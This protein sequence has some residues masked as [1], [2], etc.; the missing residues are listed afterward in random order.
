[1]LASDK[2]VFVLLIGTL[3]TIV[4]LEFIR[5]AFIYIISGW[6]YWPS[7]LLKIWRFYVRRV[8]SF[9]KKN[10]VKIV[11]L[12]E[13]WE[14]LETQE[15]KRERKSAR[16]SKYFISILWSLYWFL[17]VVNDF[18]GNDFSGIIWGIIGA[19]LLALWLF[20]LIKW[21]K[22]NDHVKNMKRIR[23]ATI[24]TWFIYVLLIW[25]ILPKTSTDDSK[26]YNDKEQFISSINLES[27]YIDLSNYNPSTLTWKT[28]KEC[29]H[30]EIT[31]ISYKASKWYELMDEINVMIDQTHTMESDTIEGQID[32][33]NSFSV[34]GNKLEE[35]IELDRQ[36]INEL[37]F[38]S[39]KCVKVFQS[40]DSTYSSSIESFVDKITQNSWLLKARINWLQ[41]YVKYSELIENLYWWIVDWSYT[42]N[43]IEDAVWKEDDM[44]K[45]IDSYWDIYNQ[46]VGN[47]EERQKQ[48]IEKLSQFD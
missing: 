22:T 47:A 48:A 11:S 28:L 16:N 6:F 21:K 12:N 10:K 8:E 18:D 24:A 46:E 1:M 14:V 26:Y 29:M 35:L 9:S 5:G 17:S 15:Q 43:D 27:G 30:P 19:V 34:F 2:W 39:K 45:V 33:K 32:I 40:M 7:W 42:Q 13:E 41:S 3:I 31:S 20:L 36:H 23:N 25:N 38:L 44:L 4:I 37:D